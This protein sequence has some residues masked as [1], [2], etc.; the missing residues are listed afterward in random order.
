MRW[1]PNSYEIYTLYHVDFFY[2]SILP[3]E[4]ISV[5][6]CYLAVTDEVKRGVAASIAKALAKRSCVMPMVDRKLTTH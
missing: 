2:F 6:F 3:D 1:Q 4:Y 5:L